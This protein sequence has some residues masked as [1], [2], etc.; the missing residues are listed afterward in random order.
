MIESSGAVK[1]VRQG[2]TGRR[3]RRILS[4]EGKSAPDLLMGGT[5]AEVKD[6]CKPIGETVCVYRMKRSSR[7]LGRG[8]ISLST[9]S[10]RRS[11][12]SRMVSMR[13]TTLSW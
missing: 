10:S 9:M 2:L 6:M 3:G 8:H 1:Q 4:G 12:W 7:Y 11:M 13:G 5:G